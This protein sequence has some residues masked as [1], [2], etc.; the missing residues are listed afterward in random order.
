MNKPLTDVRCCDCGRLLFKM[1]DGALRGALSIKCPRCR[2][3]NS[4]RPASPVPDR[5]ER[6][7]KDLLCG[8]SSHPTT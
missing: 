1:E 3:Y 8:C 2:A 6:A 5:P 4:L 7:G